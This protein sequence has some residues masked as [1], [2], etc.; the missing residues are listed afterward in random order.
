ME[1]LSNP[2]V[3]EISLNL[4]LGGLTKFRL[5]KKI[6]MELSLLPPLE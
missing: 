3:N 2:F 5:A 6:A 4:I 1:E